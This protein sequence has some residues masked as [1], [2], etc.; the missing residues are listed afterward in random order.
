MAEPTLA[1]LRGHRPE[2]NAMLRN[3]TT[4]RFFYLEA[5]KNY[6][7]KQ[8]VGRFNVD[9]YPEVEARI[10]VGL[11]RI[12]KRNVSVT[13][14]SDK[15][16]RR[17]FRQIDKMVRDTFR[18]MEGRLYRDMKRLARD[19]REHEHSMLA[20]AFPGAVVAVPALATVQSAVDERPAYGR[21]VNQWTKELA[22]KQVQDTQQQVQIGVSRGE[23]SEEVLRRVRG[24]SLARYE[25]GVHGRSRRHLQG[26]LASSVAH[27]AYQ[28]RE[29]G[30]ELN[31]EIVPREQW[32]CVLDAATCMEC[33]SWHGQV[34]KVT[35]GP[36]PPMHIRCRCIRIPMGLGEPASAQRFD[37]W[38]VDQPEEIIVEA[39]GKARAKLFLTGRIRVEDFTN[40]VGRTYTLKQLRAKEPWAFRAAGL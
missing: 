5:Y 18:E 13:E 20:A 31:V 38:L 1:E 8:Y 22:D 32:S 27:V 28:T 16:L 9:L 30:R 10:E 17:L 37:D 3:L 29:V 26:V 7:V 35:E 24:T 39:L 36:S 25:D 4:R 33:M 2:T 19:E 34:F 6:L 15:E 21:T 11:N 12:K 23:G 14:R 40:S